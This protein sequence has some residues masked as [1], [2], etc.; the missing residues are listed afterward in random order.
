M[1]NKTKIQSKYEIGLEIA[2]RAHKGQKRKNSK[3]NEE[4]INHPI[5]VAGAFKNDLIRA[6][7]VTHDVIE[8][9]PQFEE[10]IKARLGEE[11]RRS[12]KVLSRMK[13]E[14][15]FDFILRIMWS[16]DIDDVKIKIE[17]ITDN[18]RDIEEGHKAD[19]YR[20]ARYLLEQYLQNHV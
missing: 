10:E 17:D 13:G 5:R 6:K 11:V 3:T 18:L 12:G 7:A 4:Y 8:D 20:L 16:K 9:H 19:K 1:D 15:Y 2:M 14:S